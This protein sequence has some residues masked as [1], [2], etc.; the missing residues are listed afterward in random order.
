MTFWASRE[1]NSDHVNVQVT[2]SNVTVKIQEHY[3]HLRHFWG[4]L[5]KLLDEAEKRHG[6]KSGA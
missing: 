3:M 2:S 4:E 5:G 1:D 6:P